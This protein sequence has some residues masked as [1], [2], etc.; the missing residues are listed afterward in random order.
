MQS[1]KKAGLV[2]VTHGE[3]N[4]DDGNR[5]IQD[6]FGVDGLIVDKILQL[7]DVDM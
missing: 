7:R 4:L 6:Q 2:L 1:I 3:G 5:Q